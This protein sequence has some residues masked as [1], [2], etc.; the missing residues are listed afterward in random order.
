M[1]KEGPSAKADGL[2]HLAGIVAH[3]AGCVG[4]LTQ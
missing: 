3:H 4:F 1:D 2:F